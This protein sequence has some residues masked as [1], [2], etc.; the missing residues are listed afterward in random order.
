M[1][2]LMR[3][4]FFDFG[5]LWVCLISGLNCVLFSF[6]AVEL[7]VRSFVG[8]VQKR[9][10]NFLRKLVFLLG[11]FHLDINWLEWVQFQILLQICFGSHLFHGFRF[12]Y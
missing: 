3:F 1:N 9:A 8:F 6:H 5:L 11:S 4:V 2:F 12:G 10:L 7:G